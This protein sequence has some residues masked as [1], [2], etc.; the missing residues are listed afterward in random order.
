M[1]LKNGARKGFT[2]IE[3]LVVIAI[4]GVLV[5]LLLPA[6]QQAREAARR[7]SCVNNV[8]QICLAL[9]NF[10]D[11]R[12]TF[13]AA[14]RLASSTQTSA[15]WAW[16]AEILPML[17]WQGLYDSLEISTLMPADLVAKS[18]G[19]P[20][21]TVIPG[22]LCP[23]D[24]PPRT[25]SNKGVPGGSRFGLSNYPGVNGDEVRAVWRHSANRRGVFASNSPGIEPRPSNTGN[26]PLSAAPTRITDITDGTSTTFMV[27]ERAT[28]QLLVSHTGGVGLLP[29]NDRCYTSWTSCQYPD[30]DNAGWKGS[31]EILGSTG[32]PMNDGGGMN[33]PARYDFRHTFRSTHPGGC[34]FGYADGSVE[35]VSEDIGLSIFK[36]RATIQG[37]ENVSR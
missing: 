7:S 34:V 19:D 26:R 25:N 33:P 13:P 1:E 14:H 16:S 22:Y 18:A 35:F 15:G 28:D 10:H 3:L 27:G 29:D 23:A 20:L 11:V 30:A 37:G 17:E 32:Q 9:H 24:T 12:K 2:L 4:I 8:K 21:D 5:G 36:G 6:V 31:F